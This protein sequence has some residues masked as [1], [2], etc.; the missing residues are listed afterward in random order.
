MTG[1]LGAVAKTDDEPPGE[2]HAATAPG[3]DPDETQDVDV[4]AQEEP[5]QRCGDGP[6]EELVK[7]SV[8]DVVWV[9]EVC[10]PCARDASQFMKGKP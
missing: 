5:C 2:A 4:N 8:R 9:S 6:R 10:R 1:A 3:V 7:I